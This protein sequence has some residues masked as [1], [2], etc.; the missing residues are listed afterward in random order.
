MRADAEAQALRVG[1]FAVRMLVY[2]MLVLPALIVVSTSF[3]AGDVLSFPPK[4]FSL[5]WY[6]S[7]WQSAPIVE[8]LWLSVRLALL[9]TAISLTIGISAA[10][11]IDRYRFPGRGTLRALILSPLIIPAVVLGLGLL[12]FLVWIRLNQTFAGLVAA[13]IVLTLPYVV[14]TLLASMA[15]F[16]RV[17]EE[18]GMSL[19]ASPARVFFSITLPLLMPAIVSAFIFAFVTS[20]GN[21]TLSVFLGF[22]QYVTLPVQIFTYVEHSFDPMIAAVS[23]IVILVTITIIYV[24]EKISGGKSLL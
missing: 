10:F 4:G 16:N 14:R 23:S 13:H 7:A 22:G 8:S 18:A 24:A 11:A 15:L 6:Q 3:T 12:Q 19:R 1:G 5:R 21:V 2:L 9:A 17:L 20:F